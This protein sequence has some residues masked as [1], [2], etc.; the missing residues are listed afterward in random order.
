MRLLRQPRK[1]AYLPAITVRM[2]TRNIPEEWAP[3]W[4]TALDS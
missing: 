1:P 4:T 2:D 3:Y